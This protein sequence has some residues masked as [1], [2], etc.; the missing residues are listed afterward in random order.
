MRPLEQS[1]KHPPGTALSSSVSDEED[2]KALEQSRAS[3]TTGL[4]VNSSMG[5]PR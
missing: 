3:Q 1:T 5:R 4:Y 2:F